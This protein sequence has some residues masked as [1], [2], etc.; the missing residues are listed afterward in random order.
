MRAFGVNP[1]VPSTH[2][3]SVGSEIPKLIE[4]QNRITL[5][6]MPNI[7]DVLETYYER[8]ANS[9]SNWRRLVEEIKDGD[10][11]PTTVVIFETNTG[12]LGMANGEPQD[13]TGPLKFYEFNRFKL[14]PALY[15]AYD[16][17][18]SDY[19]TAQENDDDNPVM[20]PVRVLE[21][22]RDKQILSTARKSLERDTRP[23]ALDDLYAAQIVVDLSHPEVQTALKNRYDNK[24][25]RKAKHPST[26]GEY[27]Q[28]WARTVCTALPGYLRSKAESIGITLEFTNI[29]DTLSTKEPTGGS[30][31]SRGVYGVLKMTVHSINTEALLRDE[32]APQ[33][34]MELMI[35]PP[36]DM[37]IKLMDDR[38]YE[39]RRMLTPRVAFHV[40]GV[41]FPDD[42]FRRQVPEEVH[43][44]VFD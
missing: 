4:M 40:I 24:V 36:K 12:K 43:E 11:E 14:D 15:N 25:G 3:T 28:Q 17:K 23:E 7:A 13:H 21:S 6:M 9:S 42:A 20:I 5:F 8:I 1:F 27:Y 29:K 37:I 22:V 18:T 2:H 35:Y 32:N 10:T 44:I 16:T 33:E 38:D 19:F 31:A 26:I 39:V 30:G 34:K 41:L